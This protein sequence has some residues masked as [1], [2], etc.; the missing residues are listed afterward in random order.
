M[1]DKPSLIEVRL[2]T[3]RAAAAAGIVFAILLGV[4]FGLLRISLPADPL[5][6]GEWLATSAKTVGLSVTLVPFAGI[7]FLWFLG[8]FRDR[9]GGEEDR[10]FA[11]VFLGSAILFLSMLFVGAAV[12]GAIVLV[13]AGAPADVISSA[14]F[15]FARAAAYNITNVYAAKMAGVFMMSASTLVLYTKVAPR[16]LAFAGFGG[17][18]I[19]LLGSDLISWNFAVL[20]AWVLMISLHILWDNFRLSTRWTSSR[21]PTVT[22][23]GIPPRA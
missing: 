13:F 23:R 22:E 17:A 4:I 5:D 15:R 12:I 7:A 8:V 19:L 2:R 21:S 16:W 9:V 14:S 18:F 3:P 10:F 6:T 1:P 20:P 11:T